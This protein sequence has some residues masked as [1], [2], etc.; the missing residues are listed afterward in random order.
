MDLTSWLKTG[1]IK[2]RFPSGPGL[3]D[4]NE[5]KSEVEANSVQAANDAVD[6]ILLKT[7][8]KKKEGNTLR[9]MM[10]REQKSQDMPSTMESLEPPGNFRDI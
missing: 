6:A 10:K 7:P 4:P 5:E 8:T 1:K 2:K 9:T 3:P